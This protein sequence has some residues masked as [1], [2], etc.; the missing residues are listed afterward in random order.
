ML[1]NSA[2][3]LQSHQLFRPYL[4]HSNFSLNGM[5]LEVRGAGF[6]K[7][8]QVN[9]R[10]VVFVFLGASLLSEAENESLA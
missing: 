2:V 7:G 10:L 3:L 6:D 5:L 8:V 4:T 9:D 1:N